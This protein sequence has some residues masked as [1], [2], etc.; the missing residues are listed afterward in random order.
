MNVKGIDLKNLGRHRADRKV[1][2]SVTR[3]I[4]DLVDVDVI[5]P[6]IVSV[7]LREPRYVLPSNLQIF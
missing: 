2:H 5:V 1:I 7:R 4:S 6:V 3:L